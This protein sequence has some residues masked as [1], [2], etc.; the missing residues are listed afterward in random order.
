M[1][2]KLFTFLGKLSSQHSRLVVLI[3]VVL[4]L[5]AGVYAANT[6]TLNADLDRLVSEELDY[7]KRYLDFLDE[8][9]D[10]EYLYVVVE[11]G[12]DLPKA[13][14]FATDVAKRFEKI[15]D[16]KEITYKI[17]NPAM[18]QGFM[19]YL[20]MD[21]LKALAAI[22]T[23]GAF[24]VRQVAHWKTL[25]PF[26]A[27]INREVAG[28]VDTSR[29]KELATSFTFLDGVIDDMTAT[30]A[31][32]K[33]YESCLQSLFFGDGETFD[34]DG[35][36][37]NGDLLFIMIMPEKDFTT[38]EVIAEPLARI[39]KAVNET[40]ANYPG[41]TAGLTG[42]PVLAADE[43]ATTDRD[44]TKATLLA[45]V[46][47]GL[48]FVFFFRS[49]V[50]PTLA[51]ASLIM[52]ITWTFGV[53]AVVFGSLT[54]LSIVFALILVGASI[55]YAIHLVARYQEEL[56][57]GMDVRTA[58]TNALTT[59][60]RSNLTSAFT[61]AGAFLTITW[62]DFTAIAEL[63]VIAASGVI[64]CL[65]SMLVVLP[66]MLVIRDT[67]L[68]AEK[69]KNVKP[70]GLPRLAKIYRH[71]AIVTMGCV[72]IMVAAVPFALRT[73]FDNNLLNLQAKGLESVELEHLI[74]EKSS[75]TTWFANSTAKT[76]EESHRKA[77]ELRKLKTVRRVDDIERIVPEQQ[78]EKIEVVKKIA[79]VFGKITF[80]KPDAHVD[81]GALLGQLDKLTSSLGR[82]TEGA[83]SSGRVDAVEELEA[84]GAKVK[85]LRD[86]VAK[87]TPEQL[88]KLGKYQVSFL[89]DMQTN[90]KLLSTGMDP[91]PITIEDLPQS[92]ARRFV[93]PKGTYALTIY[94]KE[95]IWDP[96]SLE[97][98][99]DEVR[100]LDPGVLGTPI[101]VHESGRLMRET[102]LKSA[103]LAFIVI[104]VMVLIDF[105]RVRP[106]L[107]AVM[108]L[109]VGTLWLVGL[110]GLFGVPFNMANFFAIPILIGIGVDNGVHLAHRM[111]RDNCVEAIGKSTGKGVMLTALAN[112]IGF[113][114]MMLAAHRGIASLGQIMAIGGLT[115]LVAALVAM[116]PV[117][118]WVMRIPIRETGARD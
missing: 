115:M 45:I 73:S 107:M 69:L 37:R 55:E 10:M 89:S 31:N 104:F 76:V 62:T 42:R 108:P 98:F 87:A 77:K 33:Q 47:V 56:A 116:P 65:I 92:I 53:V 96:A 5:V 67:R 103:I 61:T 17:D 117:A 109:A 20:P 7:H 11:I 66:A 54:I 88:E 95:N 94:P 81:R 13:K 44:M 14:R 118:H 102:F 105:K 91:K 15:Q 86:G 63:G 75:E 100:A 43:L 68:S 41:I 80:D 49:F 101:E 74:I 9:G 90:L 36:L 2:H 12:D 50:R 79:P 22:L 52:G 1:R 6:I 18:E 93:S 59:A 32:G 114:A 83:F 72:L 3:A 8:F 110:M 19:L 26:F 4:T 82:L 40:K 70:F 99:I 111:Q 46:L 84:F 35:F 39:R 106:A 24:D 85:M 28:P 25:T 112:A 23:D 113:G 27:A 34:P 97:E 64:L 16:I 29:E 57:K 71:P 21:E 78:S 51:M 38:M 48:L 30:L 60:G 58:M